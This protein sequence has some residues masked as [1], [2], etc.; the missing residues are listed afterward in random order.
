MEIFVNFPIYL[1]SLM[2]AIWIIFLFFFLR[3]SRKIKFGL[4]LTFVIAIL[5][6]AISEDHSRVFFFI[7]FPIL[8]S[9]IMTTIKG[10]SGQKL[11]LITVT[12]LIVS[13]TFPLPLLWASQ[14][15]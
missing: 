2:G 3:S 1:W 10:F 12:S 8:L 11:S 7:F 9:T 5:I 4:S 6:S 13:L 15:I 14:I